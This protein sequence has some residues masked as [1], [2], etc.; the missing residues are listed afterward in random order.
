MSS[1]SK[2]FIN[3]SPFKK[4][5][6]PSKSNFFSNLESHGNEFLGFPEEKARQRTDEYLG[7]N[8]D[9]DGPIP[10]QNSFKYGDTARHY[11]GGDQLSRSIR[12]KLGLFG[13]TSLGR[14][15]G[16]IGSNVGGLVHEARNIKEGRP[17]LES[18]EDATNNFVGSM[19]SL[20]P[21]KISTKL[22]DKVKKILPDGKVKD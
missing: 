14:A 19:Y 21:K 13:E 1:F 4:Q 18:V 11:M 6:P 20:L 22:L 12:K 2:K 3:T 15:I 5:D 17:V 9:A 16:V 10:A 7:I 8:P